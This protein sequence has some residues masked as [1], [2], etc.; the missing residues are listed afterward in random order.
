MSL[1]TIPVL[2]LP[3]PLFAFSYSYS[4]AMISVV[5]WGAVMGI[6]ETIMRAAIADLTPIGH[7]GFAY[8]IFNT[9]YGAS[10][11]FGSTLMGLM[12]DLSISYLILFVVVMEVISIPV[13]FLV[14]KHV[15]LERSS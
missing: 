6:H 3:I 14:K 1:I 15:L 12:Y 9:V 10:W 11:F 7:R 8:G 5:L 13:F 4:L 2:T